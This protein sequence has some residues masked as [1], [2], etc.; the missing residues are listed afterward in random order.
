MIKNYFEIMS[1]CWPTS[2]DLSKGWPLPYQKRISQITLAPS[3]S[4]SS[5][6]PHYTERTESLSIPLAL[7]RKKGGGAKKKK[8]TIWKDPFKNEL[9]K[10]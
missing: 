4:P 9:Q 6:V 3:H 10:F 1:T 5:L 2:N 7:M 8:A